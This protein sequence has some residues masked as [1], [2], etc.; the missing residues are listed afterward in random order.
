[1]IDQFHVKPDITAQLTN[2]DLKKKSALVK[3]VCLNEHR[4][5][6]ESSTFLPINPIRPKR[7]NNCPSN[8]PLSTALS[9]MTLQYQDFMTFPK[10][11][12]IYI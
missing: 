7:G 2:E 11:Y 6:W 1:M 9:T 10:N 5:N 3:H 4:I 12:S 8:F